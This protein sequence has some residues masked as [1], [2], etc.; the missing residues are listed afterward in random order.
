M[1]GLQSS[2]RLSARSKAGAGILRTEGD[3]GN[4]A[5]SDDAV[6]TGI[7]DVSDDPGSVPAVHGLREALWEP[8]HGKKLIRNDGC[9]ACPLHF[10]RCYVIAEGFSVCQ[11][12]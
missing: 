7:S 2:E 8:E 5:A 12:P 10:F 11:E 1:L 3:D 4:P 6:Q 9:P